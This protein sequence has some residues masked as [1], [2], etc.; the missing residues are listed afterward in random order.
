MPQSPRALLTR[1]QSSAVLVC[2]NVVVIAAIGLRHDLPPDC[3]SILIVVAAAIELFV[4][5]FSGP[6]RHR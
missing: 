5:W 2:C 6:R 3:A 1:R 4:I